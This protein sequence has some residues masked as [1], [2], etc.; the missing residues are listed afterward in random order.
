MPQSELM[1]HPSSPRPTL[2]IPNQGSP[3]FLCWPGDIP[4]MHELNDPRAVSDIF[5]PSDRALGPP[6]T[7]DLSRGRAGRSLW[8]EHPDSPVFPPS[9]VWHR[10][11]SL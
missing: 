9:H 4:N 6:R 1:R 2:P 5:K 7:V 8:P 10:P 11:L 3:S